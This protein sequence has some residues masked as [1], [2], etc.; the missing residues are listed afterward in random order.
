MAQN[1]CIFLILSTDHPDFFVKIQKLILYMQEK[2]QLLC[3][4]HI[5]SVGNIVHF[6]YMSICACAP[7]DK[8]PDLGKRNVHDIQLLN[9]TFFSAPAGSSSVYFHLAS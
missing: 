9:G 4:W 7:A 6:I 2:R 1:L 5:F 3:K 8:L